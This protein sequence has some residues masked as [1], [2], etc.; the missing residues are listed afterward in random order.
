MKA[1]STTR[2]RAQKLRRELTAAEIIMWAR[3]K[4]RR[5][6]GCQFRCQHP[7]GPYIADFACVR[8]K[9]VVEVDG[10][11]HSTDQERRHDAR[12]TAFL[13]A[14][15]WSVIRFWNHEV[16]SNTDGVVSTIADRLRLELDLQSKEQEPPPSRA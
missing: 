4:S 1:D 3:L 6:L 2:Y 16:K 8:L 15:G 11:T 10:E 12:R 9:L 13:E 7:I 14:D 5:V